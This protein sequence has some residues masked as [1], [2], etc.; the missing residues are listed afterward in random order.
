MT[1]EEVVLFQRLGVALALGLLV[2]VERGWETRRRAEGRRVAGFRTFGLIGLLG[3][4]WALI[5]AETGV[6]VLAVAFA[7]L[8]AVL[9]VSQIQFLRKDGDV[10]ATTMVA[11]LVTFA[12]GALAGYGEMTLAAAGAVVVTLLLGV[13][14]QLHGLVERL[15]RDELMAVIKLLLMSVVLLPV[16]PDRGYGPWQA[17]NPYRIW[18]MV[19]L[20]AGINFTGYMAIKLAGARRGVLLTGLFGGLASSTAT[21]IGLARLAKG[22]TTLNRLAAA[23]IIIAATTMLPRMLLVAAV[24]APPLALRL[25]GPLL[26]GT[27]TGCGAAAWLWQRARRRATP[28]GVARR[29][30]FELSVALQFGALLAVVMVLSYALQA[31]LGHAGLYLLGAVSGL[32]DV[33][34]VTLSLGARVGEA[35]LGAEVAAVAILLAA[36]V[37]TLVKAALAAAISGAELAWR[38]A[39]GAAAILAGGALGLLLPVPEMSL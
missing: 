9:I 36:A 37:N 19:V 27:L 31:W 20:I 23:G 3:G 5:A 32:S 22:T 39:L 17:L 12:L 6:L 7:A 30:P 21:T 4:L 18:W 25:A 10:G 35:S 33:D 11:A 14:P 29:N 2:G 16:L 26:L 28:D 15:E 13:K 38:V 34:A 8:A 1:A 24:V